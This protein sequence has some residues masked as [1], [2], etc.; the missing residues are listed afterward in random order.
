MRRLIQRQLAAESERTPF[1]IDPL[2]EV[3]EYLHFLYGIL[4]DTDLL[5]KVSHRDVECVAQLINRLKSL[6]LQKEV[7]VIALSDI[8]RDRDSARKAATRILQNPDM[9][10]LYRKIYLAKEDAVEENIALCA[11]GAAFFLLHRYEGAKRMRPRGPGQDVSAQLPGLFQAC[12]ALRK[13]WY[14][15]ILDFF[16]ASGRKWICTCR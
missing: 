6:V 12:V 9:Y 15:N 14:E 16:K 8:P 13:H 11:K 10:S 4:D 1:F 7:E 2:R 3:V 5:T